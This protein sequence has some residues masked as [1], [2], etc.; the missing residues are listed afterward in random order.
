MNKFSFFLVCFIIYSPKYFSQKI[1]L[2]PVLG[3]TFSSTASNNNISY[4]IGNE[5][6]FGGVLA[7]SIDSS[8]AIFINYKFSRP[9]T[10]KVES[11]STKEDVS[12]GIE[13]YQLGFSQNLGK[14]KFIPFIDLSLGGTHY[15]G[16]DGFEMDIW[17]FSG[18]V[19]AGIKHFINQRIGFRIHS[20]LFFPINL[21]GSNFVCDFASKGSNNCGDEE[22][23]FIPVY[24]FELNAGFIF[25]LF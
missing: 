1:E 16:R 17:K 15:Y 21:S 6:S 18:A 20:N 12:I 5:L 3:Y 24:H 19:G 23:K 25:N 9:L 13:N 7:F 4:D 2:I 22:T 10:K 14:R 8:T 11:L